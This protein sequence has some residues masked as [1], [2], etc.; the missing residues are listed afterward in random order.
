MMSMSGRSRSG[1]RTTALGCLAAGAALGLMAGLAAAPAHAQTYSMAIAYLPPE[2]LLNNEVHPALTHFKNLIEGATG[3]DLQ[4]ELFGGGQLGSE[5]ETGRQAQTGRTLQSTVIS[6][7]AMSSFYPDYQIITTPFLFPNYRVAR[8]FFDG[9]WMTEFMRG[10]IDAAELRYLGTMDDG[11]G[12]VAFTTNR[13]LITSLED[14]EGL[15]IRVEENPAHVA[16]MEALGASATPLPWG[17]V[18]TA[19][20]TG[21]ADGQFN[22]PGVQ[23]AYRIWEVQDYTTMSGHVYNSLT[24]LVSERWF[25]ELPEDYRRIVVDAAREAV[26]VSHGMAALQAIIGWEDSCREFSECHILAAEERERMAEIARPAWKT[27][28]TQDFGVEEALVDALW[29]EVARIAEE[30]GAS[31]WEHYGQ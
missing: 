8:A 27:W 31:D 23:R 25:Q 22:A 20:A 10:T 4:V 7:G 3:G 18:L 5:V 2:D 9:P 1:M 11:G 6:S 24:W 16:T 28:I 21:L 30:V 19:L 26:Q 17:E 29:A 14:I 13:R 15:I 12:F